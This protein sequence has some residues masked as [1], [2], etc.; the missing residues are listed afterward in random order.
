MVAVNGK[1]SNVVVKLDDLNDFIVQMKFSSHFDWG[2]EWLFGLDNKEDVKV[3]KK[4][5]SY[6]DVEKLEDLNGRVVRII[7]DRDSLLGV[8]DPIEDK[9]IPVVGDKRKEVIYEKFIN[10]YTNEKVEGY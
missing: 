7:S 9:F 8:G 6:A 2:Y 1:I 4:L 3:L 5:M 10:P